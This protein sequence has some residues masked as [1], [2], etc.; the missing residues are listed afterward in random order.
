MSTRTS[1]DSWLTALAIIRA[2]LDGDTEAFGALWPDGL[3][4]AHC[5]LLASLAALAAVAMRSDA[6]HEGMST[7]R[8]LDSLVRSRVEGTS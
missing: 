8:Y 2:A 1:D 5:E 7:S 6:A 3:D 4:D